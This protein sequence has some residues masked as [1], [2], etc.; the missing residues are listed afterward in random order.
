VTFPARYYKDGHFVI[1]GSD[2]GTILGVNPWETPAQLWERMRGLVPPKEETDAMTLGKV[3]EPWLRWQWEKRHPK[4]CIESEP[5]QQE[6]TDIPWVRFSPDGL[7]WTTDNSHPPRV[8]VWEGKT[9]R[10]WADW[11]PFGSD[12]IPERHLCQVQLYMHCTQLPEAWVS[13]AHVRERRLSSDGRDPIESLELVY[14]EWLV[15]YDQELCESML[16]RAKV[17]VDLVEAAIRPVPGSEA[18]VV[19]AWKESQ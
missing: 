16:A 9:T 6:I 8:A 7:V 13:C 1:G 11:G 18:E 5:G 10:S 2:L 4:R 19:A 14:G 12:Q 15:P 3:L 17:F